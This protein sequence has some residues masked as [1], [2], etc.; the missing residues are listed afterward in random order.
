VKYK[1]VLGA[2]QLPVRPPIPDRCD[3]GAGYREVLW[4][5]RWGVGR[6]DKFFNSKKALFSRITGNGEAAA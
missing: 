1:A 4:T 6:A 5:A 2:V 3:R